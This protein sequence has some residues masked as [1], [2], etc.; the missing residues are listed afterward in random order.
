MS[1]MAEALEYAKDLVLSISSKVIENDL[2]LQH[3]EEL[4]FLINY[5]CPFIGIQDD[6]GLFIS[7]LK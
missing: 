5:G 1:S 4:D 3:I 6:S 2:E 7:F